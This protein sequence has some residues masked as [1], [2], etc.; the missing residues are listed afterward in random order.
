[1]KKKSAFLNYLDVTAPFYYFYLV[2]TVIALV[3]VSF[4]FSFQGLFPTTIDSSISSQHKFLNDYFAICNFF[5][6]GLI[7][8]NYLRHPLPTKYVKQ[9]RQH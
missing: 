8:I 7:V 4:V 3:I 5:V 9:I 2:P 6:I 1:M